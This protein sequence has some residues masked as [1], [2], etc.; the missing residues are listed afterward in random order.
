MNTTTKRQA[1]TYHRQRLLLFLLEQAG[2]QL[3]KM[4][5]QKLLFLAHQ[6]GRFN[7]YEFVP[8]H[9]GCWSFQA[10][11]DL[12]AL[13]HKGWIESTERHLSL[14]D[15]PYLGSGAKLDERQEIAILMH[16]YRSLR[17]DS[18]LSEVYNRFPYYAINS[19]IADR[20]VPEDTI[21]KIAEQKALYLQAGMRLF[22]IGYEGLSLEAY[23]NRLIQ[24]N[25]RLLCDV[26]KNPL[27]RKFGFSKSTHAAVLPKI[28]IEYRH[29]PELGIVSEK[30]QNL[31]TREDY[32]RLF[33]EYTIELPKKERH[34][35]RLKEWFDQSARIALTCYEEQ[36]ESCHRSRV[37]SY[38]QGRW[39]MS[40]DDRHGL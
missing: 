33:S 35:L 25:V 32:E 30:R 24:N 18:L 19:R 11:D 4:D 38:L 28:G 9:F 7:Y 13:E 3:S 29:I 27:S 37:S 16:R 21:E 14:I 36:P 15:K 1:P 20:V 22:T 5:F 26:R 2:G 17:G 39:Q 12:E 10:A 6:T 40:H 23:S 34:L 8:Y 31:E